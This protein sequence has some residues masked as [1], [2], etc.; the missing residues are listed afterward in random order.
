MGHVVAT[1]II[2]V[3]ATLVLVVN[4]QLWS[5]HSVSIWWWYCI[6]TRITSTQIIANLYYNQMCQRVEP[7]PPR[8]IIF[9]AMETST[10]NPQLLLYD[11]TYAHCYNPLAVDTRIRMHVWTDRRSFSGCF[12]ARVN[13]TADTAHLF[14]SRPVSNTHYSHS[15]LVEGCV[16]IMLC[17]L[18]KSW[19]GFIEHCVS[20]SELVC[21]CVCVCVRVHSCLKF[22]SS[23]VASMY[24]ESTEVQNAWRWISMHTCIVSGAYEHCKAALLSSA[25][26]LLIVYKRL[27]HLMTM[28][29]L[30]K[31]ISEGRLTNLPRGNFNE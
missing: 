10:I 16:E 22:D 20:C 28:Y 12:A 25:H 11:F 8:R 3:N 23:N 29:R 17:L 21:V 26:M 2:H 15:Q 13:I 24:N 14:Q 5:S 4:C 1:V 19:R 7:S 30:L 27:L 6:G 31:L 9:L 18:T